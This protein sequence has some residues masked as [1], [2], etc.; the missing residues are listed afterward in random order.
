[1]PVGAPLLQSTASC[2]IS[3][4]AGVRRASIGPTN[5]VGAE[6]FL[7]LETEPVESLSVA[8]SRA[9]GNLILDPKFRGT[10]P[11]RAIATTPTASPAPQL[12]HH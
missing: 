4:L 6:V 2:F 11:M 8:M 12:P 10:L 9:V 1:M 7:P 5:P 3:P